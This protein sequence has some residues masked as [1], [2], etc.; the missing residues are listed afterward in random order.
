MAG[1]DASL[2]RLDYDDYVRL[3][4]QVDELIAAFDSHPDE[5]TRERVLALLTG[6]D[7]LHRTAL[8]RLVEGLREHGAG[9]ALEGVVRDRVVET[10][11]GLYG[12]ADLDIPEEEALPEEGEALAFVPRDRLTMRTAVKDA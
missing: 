2:D 10:L 3:I 8:R 1:S 7:L 12:L 5:A 6:V 4:R 11:L 9:A